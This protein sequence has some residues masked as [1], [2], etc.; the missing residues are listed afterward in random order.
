[1][2]MQRWNKYSNKLQAL[3]VTK[4][5]HLLVMCLKPPTYKHCIIWNQNLI[6]PYKKL[7]LMINIYIFYKL[8]IVSTKIDPYFYKNVCRCEPAWANLSKHQHET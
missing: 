1:M 4:K 7:I 6:I 2:N 3:K 8:Q 5:V